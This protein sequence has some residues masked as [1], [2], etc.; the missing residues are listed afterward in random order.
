[1]I[2]VLYH[3]NKKKSNIF[4]NYNKIG[5]IKQNNDETD[6]EGYR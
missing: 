5:T 2:Q 6:Y 1:M 4:N 3:I